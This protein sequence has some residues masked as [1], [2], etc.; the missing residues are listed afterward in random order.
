LIH[1][2][3]RA[4]LTTIGR[5]V[6][7][8]NGRKIRYTLKRSRVSRNIRF[9]IKP[10]EGLSIIVP[11][12]YPIEQLPPVIEAKQKWIVSKISRYEEYHASR[13]QREKM[14]GDVIPFMGRKLKLSITTGTTAGNLIALKQNSLLLTSSLEINSVNT[15]LKDWYRTQAE[16]YISKRVPELSERCGISYRKVT[17][18]SQKTRWGSCSQKGNL[19]L[20]WKLIIAPPEVID[21]VITHEL[22]HMIEMNHSRRFWKLVDEYC[23][24]WRDHKKWLRKTSLRLAEELP[25]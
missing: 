9:E 21:Y 5:Y 3:R 24:A 1:R 13:P 11:R 14:N 12:L 2:R 15:I 6:I 10:E 18:R 25:F 8:L 4:R 16:H 19:S 17:V 23:P 20:N 22:L 7:S